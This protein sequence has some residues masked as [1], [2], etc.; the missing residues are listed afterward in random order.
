MSCMS[1]GVNE[2]ERDF[3][4]VTFRIPPFAAVDAP[5][6]GREMV[7]AAM[8]IARQTQPDLYVFPGLIGMSLVPDIDL[9][10][11]SPTDNVSSELKDAYLA[12][13]SYA[14]RELAA[15]VI[16][17]SLYL[18][19][20][21]GRMQ[22]YAAVFDRQGNLVGEQLQ[23]HADH[24]GMAVGDELTPIAVDAGVKIGILLGRDAWYPET[25]RILALSGVD[26][27][28]APLA[29]VEP[30]S[31]EEAL[32]GLWQEVQQNQTYG[33]EAGLT[34]TLGGRQFGGR[35]AVY[36][37]CE[38]TPEDS[39]FLPRAGYYVGK[40]AIV[41]ELSAELLR[42]VRR[43]YPMMRQLNPTLYRKHFPALYRRSR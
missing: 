22:H 19:A 26:I 17:G 2:L 38:I 34:G 29:P 37:P 16:P 9:L 24:E 15:A 8:S 11:E 28:V 43:E 3:T 23:T 35:A 7:Q 21:S 36:A 5:S 10:S 42:R 1:Q 32:W 30:Y 40:G 14:A 31:A 25:A 12:A 18:P 4:V 6:F 27:L 20:G 13:G 33:I 41:V 39:G